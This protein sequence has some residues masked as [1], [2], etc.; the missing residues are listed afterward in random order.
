MSGQVITTLNHLA[1]HGWIPLRS[2]SFL[3]GYSHATG[4]YSRQKG[5]NPIPTVKIGGTY[6]VHADDVVK[7]LNNRPEQ[8]QAAAL[9]FLRI[10]NAALKERKL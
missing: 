9:V 5:K 4:I 6:R 7:E 3:L 8:D 10:Y 2:M 1:T